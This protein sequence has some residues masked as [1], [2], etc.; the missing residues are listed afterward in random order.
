M[1][2]MWKDTSLSLSNWITL[3][4]IYANISM[5]K[6]EK[7]FDE[8]RTYAYPLFLELSYAQGRKKTCLDQIRMGWIFVIFN[9]SNRM[10]PI[11][12]VLNGEYC[13]NKASSGRVHMPIEHSRLCLV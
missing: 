3:H 2:W 9:R 8:V 1:D 12:I 7:N 5:L 6:C 10:V 11:G 13:R 4:D